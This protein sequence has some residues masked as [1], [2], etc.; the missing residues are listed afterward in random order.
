MK[1]RKMETVICQLKE[2]KGWRAA[3]ISVSTKLW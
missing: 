2:R 3:G 1:E